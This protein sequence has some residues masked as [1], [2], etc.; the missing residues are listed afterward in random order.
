MSLNEL[1]FPTSTLK[2]YKAAFK[3]T[4]YTKKLMKANFNEF[5]CIKYFKIAISGCKFSWLPENFLNGTWF[6]VVEENESIRLRFQA[7]LPCGSRPSSYKRFLSGGCYFTICK[8]EW[9]IL[10]HFVSVG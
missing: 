9:A 2:V 1:F 4:K 7:V 6:M 5:K 10:Q 8:S 3:C